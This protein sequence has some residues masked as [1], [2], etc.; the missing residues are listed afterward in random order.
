MEVAIGTRGSKLAMWQTRHV[1]SHLSKANIGTRIQEIRTEGDLNQTTPLSQ[2]GTVGLFTRALDIALVEGEVDIAVH[3][4][5]DVPAFWDERLEILAYLKREDPRDV[6]LS[7][8]EEVHLENFN[9]SWV[10]GT[11]AMRRKA[12]LSHYCPH[13][14]IKDIRGNVDTRLQ[15]LLDGEYDGIL[16]AYAGV[17][18][19]GL[20][21]YIRQK[22]NVS[23]FTPAVAQGVVAVACRKD[24]PAQQ[25]DLIRSLMNDQATEYAVSCE[26]AFLKTIEGGCKKAVFGLAQCVGNTLTI[27][28]GMFSDDGANLYRAEG[29]GLPSEAESLGKQVAYKVLGQIS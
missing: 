28:G 18:R 2:M 17:K 27:H 3:S 13:V 4:A 14:K 29:E 10:I 1:Q 9:S 23:S 21:K 24:L 6:L 20:Q 22:L 25:K 26:R 8:S 19:M 11:S 15:K 16:L 7:T 12:L 5:K